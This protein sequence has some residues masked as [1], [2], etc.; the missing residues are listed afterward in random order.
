MAAVSAALV[1]DFGFA[2]LMGEETG[3]IPTLYASQFSFTLPQTGVVL[4][5]PK[6]YIVHPNGDEQLKGVVPDHQVR[7]HLVDEVD[8]VLD[9]TLHKLIQRVRP[10]P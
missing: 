4:K 3:A 1:H 2:E 6:G 9:Y 10:E 8:E 7:D 5:V